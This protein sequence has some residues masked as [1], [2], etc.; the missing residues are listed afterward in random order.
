MEKNPLLRT[1]VS[2][3]PNVFCVIYMYIYFMFLKNNVNVLHA[4]RG[5]TISFILFFCANPEKQH[6]AETTGSPEKRLV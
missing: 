4:Y 6:E 1:L 2:T 5:Q 3:L